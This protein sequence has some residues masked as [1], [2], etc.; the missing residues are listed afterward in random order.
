MSAR[1]LKDV[2]NRLLFDTGQAAGGAYAKPFAE[3]LDHLH[4]LVRFDADPGQ[5]AL[6]TEGLPALQTLEPAHHAVSVFKTAKSFG[7]AITANTRHLT[8]SRRGRKVTAY[9]KIQQL[10]ASDAFC[11]GPAVF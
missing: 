9:R 1:R 4:R 3:H 6:F 2:Q 5:G 7:I 8:L 10:W 11:C